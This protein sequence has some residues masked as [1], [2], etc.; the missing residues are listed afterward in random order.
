MVLWS[1]VLGC[2]VAGAVTLDREKEHARVS[3]QT[4]TANAPESRRGLSGSL[5]R[6]AFFLCRA[7]R[8]RGGE[9]KKGGGGREGSG[10]TEERL[11]YQAV[12]RADW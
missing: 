5:G 12:G 10:K 9:E 4:Q 6:A 7:E 11:I 8:G 1:V 3:L 2:K